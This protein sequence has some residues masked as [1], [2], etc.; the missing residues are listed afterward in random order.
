VLRGGGWDEEEIAGRGL[1]C[2]Y[3]DVGTPTAD[4]EF[5]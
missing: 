3:A 4:A 1:H 5:T 2:D